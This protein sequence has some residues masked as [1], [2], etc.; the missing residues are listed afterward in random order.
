[1]N[2]CCSTIATAYV[3]VF[4]CELKACVVHSCAL[5]T[6][7]DALNKNIAISEDIATE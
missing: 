3:N 7:S 5:P 4:L 6:K 2:K 1:M